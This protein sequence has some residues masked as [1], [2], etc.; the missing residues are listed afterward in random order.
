MRLIKCSSITPIK[1]ARSSSPLFSRGG[2]GGFLSIINP[3]PAFSEA[4]IQVLIVLIE[5]AQPV[6][7]PNNNHYRFFPKSETD[8]ATC[9][10]T[11]YLYRVERP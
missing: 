10:I 11:R 5:L 3:M 8:P 6:E 7:T 9:P 1:I 2:W 4:E